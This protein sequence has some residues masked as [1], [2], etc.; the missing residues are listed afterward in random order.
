[1]KM[2]GCLL[3]IQ[4]PKKKKM[5]AKVVGCFYR[6]MMNALFFL[7]LCLNISPPHVFVLQDIVVVIL[8]YLKSIL[9][10]SMLRKKLNGIRNNVTGTVK[11]ILLF[12]LG[13]VLTEI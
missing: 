8:R 5:R 13:Y 6:Q 7:A 11:K 1:M 3:L 2:N 9:W 10:S 4:N 12:L